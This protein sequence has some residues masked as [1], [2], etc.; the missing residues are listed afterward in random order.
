MYRD[1]GLDLVIHTLAKSKRKR[2]YVTNLSKTVIGASA[3]KSRL[4]HELDLRRTRSL[5][6]VSAS[7]QRNILDLRS[8]IISEVHTEDVERDIA[9]LT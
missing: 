8:L 7:R 6:E 3:A 2:P 5:R 4:V 9:T 1:E